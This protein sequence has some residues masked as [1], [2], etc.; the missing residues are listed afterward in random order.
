MKLYLLRHGHA[1]SALEAGVS[2]DGER[3]LSEMGRED[4]RRMV[5]FLAEKGGRPVLILHSPLRR[6]AQTAAEAAEILKPA[7]GLEAFGPLSNKISGEE[8]CA[9]LL[10][11]AEGLAEVLAVGHQPQLGELAEHLSGTSFSLRPGGAICLEV[12]GDGAASLLW[13]CNPEEL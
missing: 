2:G 5:R 12:A 7:Q 6:A 1:R 13:A 11:R 4:V 10:R 9:C 8:L 3:P